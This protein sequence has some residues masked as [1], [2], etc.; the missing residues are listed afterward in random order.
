MIEPPSFSSGKAFCTV[1]SVPLTLMLNSLSK[2]SSVTAPKGQIRQRRRWRKQYRFAPSPWRRSRKDDQGSQSGNVTLAR[3]R[4]AINP[5][6]LPN[7]SQCLATSSESLAALAWVLVED[8]AVVINEGGGRVPASLVQKEQGRAEFGSG[9]A[10]E[11]V[12]RS[13]NQGSP[14]LPLTPV[15]TVSGCK[16]KDRRGH[17]VEEP[18]TRRQL[19]GSRNRARICSRWS[20]TRHGRSCATRPRHRQREGW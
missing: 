1:N 11:C 6:S 15:V 13:W 5:L 19:P 7:N 2:C 12:G 17:L 10:T 18:R 20:Q 4:R 16:D 8:P 3:C 14:L 9:A